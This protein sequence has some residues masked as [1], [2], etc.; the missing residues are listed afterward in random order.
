[1]P[2]S[3]TPLSLGAVDMLTARLRSKGH[4]LLIGHIGLAS[5]FSGPASTGSRTPTSHALFK[6]KPGCFL[7]ENLV[8]I[9][10]GA[11]DIMRTTLL[12]QINVDLVLGNVSLK[13]AHTMFAA[14]LKQVMESMK[15]QLE[16]MTPGSTEHLEYVKFIQPI[17]SIIRSYA[18]EI[19]PLLDFFVQSSAH[20]W[21]GDTDPNMYAAGVVSYSLRLAKDPSRTSPQLFHYLYNGW[22]QDLVQGR[23]KQHMNHVKKGMHHWEF[24]EFMLS[25]F[26]PAALHVGFRWAGGWAL[27]ATYLPVLSNRLIKILQ[28]GDERATAAS[29]HLV[30][31]L[32]DIINELSVLHRSVIVTGSNTLLNHLYIAHTV[33]QFWLSVALP[34]KVFASSQS[35]TSKTIDDIETSMMKL[36]SQACQIQDRESIQNLEL[37]A[38]GHVTRGVQFDKFVAVLMQDL[39]ENWE[40]ANNGYEVEIGST[41]ARDNTKTKVNLAYLLG[42]P[43][44]LKQLLR[45]SLLVMPFLGDVPGLLLPTEGMKG[46]MVRDI[47]L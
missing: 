31:L 33:F 30:N 37:A 25:E 5:T 11:V 15:N 4:Y 8:L 16:S 7:Q 27:C 38:T 23:I 39:D 41:R 36:M 10:L 28:E 34:I 14:M 1:M 12:N 40:V 46:P 35:N 20:Y 3:I 47:F 6:S 13:E 2:S 17:A 24:T 42:E 32:T 21:P 22:R 9:L 45:R 43:L 19:Q 26:M 18:S 29:G 44:T